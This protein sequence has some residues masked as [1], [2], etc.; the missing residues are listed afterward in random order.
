MDFALDLLRLKCLC[1]IE[2]E[3]HLRQLEISLKLER[4]VRAGE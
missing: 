2:V 3:M 1:H 4:K